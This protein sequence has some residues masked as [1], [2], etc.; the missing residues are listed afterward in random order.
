[1]KNNGAREKA[2]KKGVAAC[3]KGIIGLHGDISIPKEALAETNELVSTI[4]DDL[5]PA[6]VLAHADRL[7]SLGEAIGV[8]YLGF[9]LYT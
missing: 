5:G 2:V 8:E 6:M 7:A 3:K 1:M 9:P 4:V